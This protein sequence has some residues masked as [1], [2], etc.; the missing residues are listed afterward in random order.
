MA[1]TDCWNRADLIER[2]IS[3][4]VYIWYTED[5]RRTRQGIAYQT[6][7][8]LVKEAKARGITAISLEATKMGRPLYEKYGFIQ[9]NHEMELP[10]ESL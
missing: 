7:D 4:A 3:H 8:L 10:E 1:R 2:L 6:L 5:I 9:M